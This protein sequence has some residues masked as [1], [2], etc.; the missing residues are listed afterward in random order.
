MTR[1]SDKFIEN[2]KKELSIG[3]VVKV[4]ITAIDTEQSRLTA[5]IKQAQDDFTP[6]STLA[7]QDKGKKRDQ[8][9][10]KSTTVTDITGIEL[11]DKFSATV[12]EVHEAQVVLS[13]KGKDAK[14]LLSLS[15]LAR[16]RSST[17]TE[18]KETLTPG[19]LLEDLVVVSKN[20]EK[21]LIIVG[22]VVSNKPS[23]VPSTSSRSGISQNTEPLFTFDSLAEGQGLE[24]TIGDQIP[25]G[26]F[27]QL[28][29]GIRGKLAWTNLA[30]NYDTVGGSNLK[31]GIKVK[32]AIIA[33]DVENKRID[34]STRKSK[35]MPSA[36]EGELKDPV[37]EEIGQLE[38]GQSI[39]GFVRSISD[40]G[41]FVDLGKDLTARV[42]IKVSQFL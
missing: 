8:S 5:S 41:L 39:R 25:T 30:D 18:C 34:L 11:G 32:C 6:A 42:Q 9:A 17:V 4:R 24:G 7:K 37:I 16:H 10:S 20:P 35:L 33:L 31:K 22:F 27:V 26:Y 15:A 38:D 19:E 28:S 29:R 36:Q 13:L 40:S 21:G 3:Q 14:A 2:I 12:A 1:C 23:L